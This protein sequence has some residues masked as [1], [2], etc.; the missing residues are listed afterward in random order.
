MVQFIQNYSRLFLTANQS[1]AIAGV[2][3]LY[4]PEQ[5]VIRN[6]QSYLPFV[7]KL[8]VADNTEKTISNVASQLRSHDKIQILYDSN[9]EGIAKRL[10]EASRLAIAE[11]Y[12]WLLT[13]DQ[14]SM[15]EDGE[16]ENY[17]LCAGS[18]L[19]KDR[20][21]MFGV[22]Y[23]QRPSTKECEGKEAVQV[24]TSGSILNLNLFSEIGDFDEA[25]FIDEVDLEYCY[26]SIV[27]GYKIIQFSNIFMVHHL[28]KVSHHKSFKNLAITPRV[29]H[30]PIRLYYMVRNYL[31]VAKKYPNQFAENDKYR[32]T[33]LLNRIKNNLLYGRK[34]FTVL[35]YLLKSWI[36]FHKGVNGKIKPN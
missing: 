3:I 21:A 12:N 14:D 10:N 34:R 30:S 1:M 15:F 36:D 23:E 7:D 29:L 25:L 5:E 4:H 33:A 17:L 11:G 2:V 32:R 27:K 16:L 9:N 8:Y 31:Y 28:G 26:R 20:T 6:I 13:M 19:Y 18:F 22:E 24:I 35:Q